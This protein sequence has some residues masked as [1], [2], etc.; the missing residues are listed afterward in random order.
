MTTVNT[1]RSMAVE[2]NA[3]HPY[4]DT[5]LAPLKAHTLSFSTTVQHRPSHSTH[6]SAT[7]M[8]QAQHFPLRTQDEQR[9]K[10]PEFVVPVHQV[11]LIVIGK[12]HIGVRGGAVG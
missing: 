9:K 4:I 12:L 5:G 7:G 6:T 1:Q 3:T 8:T 2:P 10:Y 11:I